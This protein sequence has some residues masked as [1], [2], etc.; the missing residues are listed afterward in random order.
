VVSR[1]SVYNHIIGRLNEG[2]TNLRAGGTTFPFALG[3]GFAG[4]NTPP[5]FLRF[6]R[7]LAARVLAIRGSI[8]TPGSAAATAS[9]Q[10]ALTA[11]GESF[12]SPTGSLTEGVY[13]VF[14]TAAGSTTTASRA[15][16]ARRVVV[17]H[18]SIT[19]AA[20]RQANG[21]PDARLTAKTVAL[22]T[23]V[24]PSFCATT[25]CIPTSV[26][27]QRYPE[28]TSPIP[29]IRNEELILLARRPGTSPATS[30]GRSRTSTPSARGRATWRR[31]RPRTSPR[32]ISSSPSSCSSAGSR[33]CS[34]GTG[35]WTCGASDG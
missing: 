5:T 14:S 10:A 8:A 22:A 20:P 23:P 30:P 19:A 1:D 16:A 33:C 3:T 34:K 12:L 25:N 32:A 17:A 9:Y 26:G 21:T 2:A 35:G 11:L 31:S 24:N 28:Q 6:N 29:I 7:A 15:S 13:N 4:F 27:F 18:P